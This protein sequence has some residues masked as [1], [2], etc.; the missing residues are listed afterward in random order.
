M[1]TE[2]N[3]KILNLD[4]TAMKM[5]EHQVYEP[6][7]VTNG[8]I[9]ILLIALL[10]AVLGGMFYWFSMLDKGGVVISPTS[11]RPTAEENNEPESTTA[12]ARTEAYGVVSTSDEIPA[13][14]ADVEGTNLD[15]L[16]GELDAIEAEL[17][18]ALKAEAS[19]ETTPTEGT[20]IVQ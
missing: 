3:K 5:P 16:D 17:D 6:E 7:S 19:A 1:S 18:A 10:L 13:I 11:L 14:E 9:L 8:P 4:E 15:S 12:E 20:P 2:P